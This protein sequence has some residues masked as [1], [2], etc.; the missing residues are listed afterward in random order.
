MVTLCSIG[1]VLPCSRF[2]HATVEITLRSKMAN[3]IAGRRTETGFFD[4]PQSAV[5]LWSRYAQYALVCLVHDSVTLR[6]ESR[7]GQ[8]LPILKRGTH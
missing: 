1:V 7:Y 2:G 8:K 4:D 6:S 3:F 5:M